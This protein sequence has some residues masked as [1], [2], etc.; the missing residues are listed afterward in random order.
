MMVV[1]NTS[2]VSNLAILGR[3]NLVRK[4]QSDNVTISDRSCSLV[5]Q[6]RF[7]PPQPVQFLSHNLPPAF[8]A[9]GQQRTM[10]WLTLFRR[11]GKR[12]VFA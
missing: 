7:A 11:P 9:L 10:L 8:Q 6:A 5:R 3:L 4:G 12:N 2:P 1:S